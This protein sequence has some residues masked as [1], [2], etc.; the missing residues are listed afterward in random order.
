MTTKTPPRRR[1]LRNTALAMAAAALPQSGQAKTSSTPI[2]CEPTTRDYY[3]EGPFYTENPPMLSENR[4]AAMDEPGERMIISGRVVN[5]DCSQYLPNT[6]VDVWHADSDGN[7][8]NNGYKLRGFTRANEQG[9]YLFET[10]KPGKYLNG[11][12][13]RPAHIHFKVTPPDFPQLITQLYFEGDSD[14][15]DDAAAS[16]TEGTF[17]A[18]K[19]IIPLTANADGILEGTFDI[20]VDGNGIAVGTQDLHLNT[21]MVYSVSPNP[22]SG[23]FSIQYGVFKRAK[24]GLAVYNLAGQVVAELTDEIQTPDKYIVDWEPP[25]ELPSGHYFVVLRIND[26]QVHYLKMVR[27]QG[28]L[29]RN[30]LKY[31]VM[32][33]TSYT[34]LALLCLLC[35]HI[36][37]PVFSQSDEWNLDFEEWNLEDTRP[38]LWHDTTIVENRIGLFPP[39]W[40]YRSEFIPERTGF[41][42]TTDATSGNY[43]V[44][45]SGY[46]SYQVMRMIAGESEDKPGWP[47]DFKPNKLTG[48][49]KAILLGKCDSLRAYIDVYLTAY[50]IMADKR[51]TIGEAKA[52]LPES[53]SYITF[54]LDIA[55]TNEMVMPDTVIVVLAKERFGFDA[56]PD[57]LECS[58]V[59]FDD[60]QFTTVTSTEHLSNKDSELTIYPNPSNSLLHIEAACADCVYNITLFSANGQMLKSYGAVEGRKEISTVDLLKGSYFLSIREQHSERYWFKKVIVE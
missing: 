10:I 26:L 54:E 31:C 34:R 5:L 17:D 9:F 22:T 42:R 43:A 35:S 44:A 32:R 37:A 1:F 16:I 40:H 15:A 7:Y 38:S 51:D 48:D 47:I 39:K 49:Y 25:A 3:G 55:Y 46:Y 33:H 29:I 23:Q 11:S 8:D 53:N 18:T 27:S 57:C 20:A 28:L 13:F 30:Q 52:I 36:L 21:G 45:L 2:N 56:P 60:L 41:A 58:H 12:R 59:F 6:V 50:D 14:I 24:V 19:R 4:L